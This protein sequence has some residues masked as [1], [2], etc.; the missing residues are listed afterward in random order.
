MKHIEK[1][2]PGGLYDPGGRSNVVL[3]S[4]E[5]HERAGTMTTTTYRASVKGMSST[6]HVYDSRGWGIKVVAAAGRL[7][8]WAR[9]CGSDMALVITGI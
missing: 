7:Y 6:G 3:V 5:S 8:R 2:G 9:S 1:K 4:R